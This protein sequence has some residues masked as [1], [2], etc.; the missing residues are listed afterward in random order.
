[1]Y[2]FGRSFTIFCDISDSV[3]KHK[4][5]FID[6]FVTFLTKMAATYSINVIDLKQAAVQD[7]MRTKSKDLILNHNWHNYQK[8]HLIQSLLN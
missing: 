8:T 3:N 2:L 7:P 6:A 5:T 4:M 1:M